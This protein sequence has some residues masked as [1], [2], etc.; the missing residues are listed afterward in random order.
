ME[1]FAHRT[2]AQRPQL[3]G[4][5]STVCVSDVPNS[6]VLARRGWSEGAGHLGEGALGELAARRPRELVE[7]HE[8]LRP[9][10][11]ADA[12][13]LEVRGQCRERQ[14]GVTGPQLRE[15]AYPLPERL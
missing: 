2:A 3:M 8:P 13:R 12:P 9:H 14:L 5:L 11:L 7:H 15:H 4:A 6:W 1:S 10:L